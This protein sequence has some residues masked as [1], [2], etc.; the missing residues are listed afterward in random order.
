MADQDDEGAAGLGS[1]SA[2]VGGEVS[3]PAA[4]VPEGGGAPSG[5]R[6]PRWLV[7][8]VVA[9]VVAVVVVVAGFVGW[10]VVESRRHGAAL[11][12]CSRAV[13]ALQDKTGPDRLA[14]Y[15]EAAGIKSDQVKDAK[16][17]VAM[18][19]SVKDAEG[20]R[21]RI[22]RCKPSM[23]TDGLNAE[24]GR[25]KK[26]DGEYAAVDKAAKAVIASRDAKALDDAKAALNAKKDEASR[27]LADSDG[28]VADN[29]TRDGLQQAIDQAGQAK[30][31]EAKAY[32]DATGSLQAAIDR[33]N[34]SMQAR[35]QADQQAAQA[36][37]SQ[38]QAQRQGATQRRQ[39]S[40]NSGRRGSTQTR[41]PS[42]RPSGNQGGGD[43]GSASAPA[44]DNW[45]EQA[46][47]EWSKGNTT[48]GGKPVCQKGQAC[49]IG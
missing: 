28:R 14:Q 22:I 18:A 34:A 40:S 44:Q 31:D 21:Q 15:R 8:V 43:S 5:R 10:R 19:R 3:A 17:V 33:V 9:V 42:Y 25:A 12:S 47:E 11:D 23:S 45:S 38:Q 30:G 27:L 49:G 29:A 20:I 7:P 32:R 36:Q 26:L 48:N 24:A 2:P 46:F 39:A 37:A 41:R 1:V 4:I 13:K 35:S 6:R 16:T